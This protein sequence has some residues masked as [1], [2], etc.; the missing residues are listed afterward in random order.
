[1]VVSDESK[2]G[3]ATLTGLGEERS[4]RGIGT[5][6]EPLVEGFKIDA[7]RVKEME[8]VV[9]SLAPLQFLDIIETKDQIILINIER[10]DI[11]R[12][13]YLFSIIYL[14]SKSIEFV[15]SYIQMLVLKKGD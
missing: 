11:N 13:P 3:S 1:M 6:T 4:Q 15:Y 7:K 8:D 12:M 9:K 14:N 5:L 10:R 2:A